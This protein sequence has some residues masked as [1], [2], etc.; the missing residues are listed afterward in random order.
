MKYIIPVL[1][2]VAIILALVLAFMKQFNIKSFLV[3]TI[4]VTIVI[5]SV[6]TLFASV[7]EDLIG[8]YTTITT[9]TTTEI[10]SS[11]KLVNFQDT[12]QSESKYTYLIAYGNGS[13]EET[14]YYTYYIETDYGYSYEKI[15]AEDDDVYIRYCD[16]N[17]TPRI[18]IETDTLMT[19]TVLSKEVNLWDSSLFSYFKYRKY[20]VGDIISTKSSTADERTIFYIPEDSILVEYDIDME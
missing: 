9:T 17:E 15:S 18:E 12:S 5:S 16:E 3:Y 20:N 7:S 14:M 1:I 13:S 6:V 10:S 8:E 2:L 4:S 11:T 19:E